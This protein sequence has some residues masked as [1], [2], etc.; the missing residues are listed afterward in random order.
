ML[1]ATRT[2][3]LAKNQMKATV[4][5]INNE[6]LSDVELEDAMDELDSLEYEAE[7]DYYAEDW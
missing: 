1:Q 6:N 5:K 4:D 2:F 7:L 3:L